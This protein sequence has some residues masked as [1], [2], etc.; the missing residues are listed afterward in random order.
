MGSKG[1]Y[2]S[3]ASV[4]ALAPFGATPLLS[5]CSRCWHYRSPLEPPALCTRLLRSGPAPAL[6]PHVLADEM[7][8]RPGPHPRRPLPRTSGTLW[9]TP[10]PMR[11]PASSPP[12]PQLAP[13]PLFLTDVLDDEL[14]R[15]DVLQR[16]QAEALGAR[17]PLR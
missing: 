3:A 11:L 17:T 15:L 4:S 6:L 12:A 7:A 9:Q 16:K 5:T 1:F 13:R 10:T 14:A 8:R 2:H